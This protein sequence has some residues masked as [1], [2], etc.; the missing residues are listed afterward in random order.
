MK[1]H[2]ILSFCTFAIAGALVFGGCGGGSNG[3]S[4]PNP[5]ATP[6]PGAP[7]PTPVPGAPT[8]V[9]T[10][11]PTM[12]PVSL[13]GQ[14]GFVSTRDGNSDIFL[15]DAQGNNQRS[16]SA[17]NSPDDDRSPSITPSG[18]R[19]V[20]SSN[21]PNG[22]N[23]SNFE[24]YTARADGSNVEAYT[25]DRGDFAP[26]DIEPVIS[27]DGLKIAWT[28]TRGGNRNIATMD[29]TGGNQV[30]LTSGND[31][32]DSEPAWT[33]DSRSI[34]FYSARDGQRGI[35]IMNANGS[36][37]RALLVT[38]DGSGARYRQPALSPN[39][40]LL[41]VAFDAGDSSTISLRNLDGT[42]ASTQFNAG[43]GFEVRRHPSFSPDGSRLIYEAFNGGGSPQI[44]TAQLNGS[45]ER[46]LTSQG[47]NFDARFGG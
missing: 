46:A 15:M 12:A 31:D 37:Q 39:G 9:P 36:N 44:Q 2:P 4:R 26:E 45:G 11:T 23:D 10:P 24:I 35:Y 30:V 7:T 19:I 20:W 28:T 5:T 41:A 25:N 38:P 27:P 22:A 17:I 14:I 3:P 16:F 29:I 33:S 32:T 43:S 47:F 18:A 8:P 40:Q 1:F 34:V 21:R 6:I 13:R 42:E